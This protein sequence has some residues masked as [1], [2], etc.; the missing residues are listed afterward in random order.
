M[1]NQYFGALQL[2]PHPK[3]KFMQTFEENIFFLKKIVTQACLRQMTSVSFAQFMNIIVKNGESK[4]GVL[5]LIFIFAKD[6]VYGEE[7][8][9]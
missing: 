6:P 8:E 9:I 2:H 7:L 3:I 5:W 4:I 1:W